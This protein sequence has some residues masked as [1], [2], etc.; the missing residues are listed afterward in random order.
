MS[1]G[2]QHLTP[3]H[4]QLQLHLHM[5]REQPQRM[6]VTVAG[7]RVVVTFWFMANE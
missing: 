5:N 7:L 3:I 2:G 6:A 4:I 1:T